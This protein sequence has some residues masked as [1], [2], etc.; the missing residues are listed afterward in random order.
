MGSLE[1]DFDRGV[2]VDGGVFHM[3]R[4]LNAGFD[5]E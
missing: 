2:D 4:Q 1:L 3:T 5:T